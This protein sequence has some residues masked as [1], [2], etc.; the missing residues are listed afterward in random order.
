MMCDTKNN[1]FCSCDLELGSM[2][3][4][5]ELGLEIL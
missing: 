2:T 1:S 3:L 5:H 4:M